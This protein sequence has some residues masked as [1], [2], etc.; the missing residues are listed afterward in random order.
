MKV[1]K[2]SNNFSPITITLE[3]QEEI[4]KLACL[5]NFTPVCEADR[6]FRELY[7][8]FM[9]HQTDY[10]KYWHEIITKIRTHAAIK[11]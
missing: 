6:L 3:S 2:L 8:K 10:M 11:K 4:D 7:K 9:I 1:E 5:F